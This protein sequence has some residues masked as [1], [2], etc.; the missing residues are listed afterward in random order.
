[1]LFLGCTQRVRQ[2]NANEVKIDTPVVATAIRE[3]VERVIYD[4]NNDNR[5]DT[6]TLTTPP[7][8]GDPGLFQTITIS[9]N[10]MHQQSFKAK[11]VWDLVDSSFLAVTKNEVPSKQVFIHKEPGQTLIFLF[12]YIYGAGRGEFSI[13]RIRDNKAK[14]VFDDHLDNPLQLTDFDND[15]KAELLGRNEGEMYMDIDSIN[16]RIGVYF[17]FYI[18][19]FKDSCIIDETMT[20]QYNEDNY[21]WAGLKYREDIKVA[22]PNDGSRPYI[23]Q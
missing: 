9:F 5:P 1:M 20:Q 14:L 19:S 22:Y 7:A 10:G 2:N 11:D 17:P 15:G 4:L 18:Y 12:G 13:I 6:I 23:I 8:E 16:A 3:D 21:V